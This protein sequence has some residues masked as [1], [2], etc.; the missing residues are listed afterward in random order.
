MHIQCTNPATRRLRLPW[1]DEPISF[2]ST[3]TAQTTADVGERLIDELDAIEPY[4]GDPPPD[5]ADGADG[6]GGGDG[7]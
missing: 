3:G 6:D 4:D 1:M 2:A 5:D 7:Q